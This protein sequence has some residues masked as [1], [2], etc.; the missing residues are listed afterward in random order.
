MDALPEP[1]RCS[2]CATVLHD[3]GLGGLVCRGCDQ[4]PRIDRPL[5]PAPQTSALPQ[6]RAPD[7]RGYPP[8]VGGSG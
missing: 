5:L 7:P 1:P 8:D 6:D 4:A 2:F 3:D